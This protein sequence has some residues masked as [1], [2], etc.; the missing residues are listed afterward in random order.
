MRRVRGSMK[1]AT[2][3]KI[4]ILSVFFMIYFL[5]YSLSLAVFEARNGVNQLRRIIFALMLPVVIFSI[6]WI[7]ISLSRRFKKEFEAVSRWYSNPIS[8]FLY[9]IFAIIFVL[10]F[11]RSLKFIYHIMLLW[12]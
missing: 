6:T 3:I 5:Y 4:N 8:K 9:Y 7:L 1:E 2:R 12:G 11:I 10:V